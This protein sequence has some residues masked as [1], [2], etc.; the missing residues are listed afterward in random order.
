MCT[1]RVASPERYMQE[2]QLRPIIHYRNTHQCESEKNVQNVDPHRISKA[3]P[4]YFPRGK[5]S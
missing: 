5:R 4:R 3:M 2:L 1:Q